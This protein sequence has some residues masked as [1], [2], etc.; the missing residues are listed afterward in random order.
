[1]KI[2]AII[3]E[4]NPLHLGHI[5][6]INYV[7]NVLGAENVI[8]IMSGNFTQRGEPAILNKFKRARQAVL[9]GADAVIEL[10]AVF[11]VA[12][13]EVFAKG[14]VKILDSMHVADG[15]CFGAESGTREDF[16]NLASALNDETKEFKKT[17]K[18]YLGQGFSLAKSR[19]L[20]VKDLK[21][22]D[23]DE[24]LILK[25]N[26][27]LGLEY[28]KAVLS[29]KSDMEIYP[30]KRED[31]H[32]DAKLKKG[33]TSALSIRQAVKEGRLK[34][35]KK[36]LPDYSYA[37]LK[38]FPKD[39]DKITVSALYRASLKE[40]SE[41]PDCT[42]GLEHRI[43]ALLKDNNSVE[44]L[45]RKIST[46]R[47]TEA[48]IRRIFIANLLGIKKDFQNECLKEPLYIKVLAVN[49]L[50]KNII[51]IIGENSSVPVITRKS[52]AAELKKTAKACYGIDALACDIYDLA[53]GE[54]ENH[55][56]MIIV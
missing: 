10:P 15:L 42:E 43:K 21:K 1:M 7:K 9:A 52:Q 46:K 8:V 50:N 26:N 39:F 33:I 51:S 22:E 25:P 23:F 47:Y 24:D 54:T 17:L 35:V 4:Y 16:I 32:G 2:C 55:N 3:A 12:G 11:A 27:I 56:Q 20:A 14:A 31:T 30:M 19:F 45:V 6:H 48:R 49:A 18:D 29:F 44:T 37:D 36:N 5:K 41:L 13:A 53:T 38:E 34:K 40:L 28:A